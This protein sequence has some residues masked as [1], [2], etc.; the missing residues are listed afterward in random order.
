MA[1]EVL[2]ALETL[3]VEISCSIF[4]LLDP[5]GLISVSQTCSRFRS[6]INPT[7]THLVERLLA[8]ECTEE[9]GGLAPALRS[10]SFDNRPHWDVQE[11]EAMR[12][13]CTSCLRLRPHTSFDNHSLLRLRYRKPI[14]GSPAAAM[15]TSWEPSGDGATRK[16]Q[17]RQRRDTAI[18]CEERKLRRQYGI[19]VTRNWGIDKRSQNAKTRLAAFQDA[20]MDLFSSLTISEFRQLTDSEEVELFDQT[21]LAIE[22]RRCGMKRYRRKCIECRFQ[23]SNLKP[24]GISAV[25]GAGVN[26]GTCNVPIVCSRQL[27]FATAVD[28]YFPD[29]A[30]DL[31]RKE[32][33]LSNPPIPHVYRDDATDEF[34]TMY[35]VRCPAC[36]RWQEL[37]SFRVGGTK[38]TWRPG[39]TNRLRTWDGKVVNADLID[40]FRCYQCYAKEHGKEQ[41]MRE[42]LQRWSLLAE[43]EIKSLKGRLANGWYAITATVG[44]YSSSDQVKIRSEVLN[45]LP[46][47]NHVGRF[48]LDVARLDMDM[49]RERHRRWMVLYTELTRAGKSPDVTNEFSRWMYGYSTMEDMR[50]WLMKCR[51]EIERKPELLLDWALGRDLSAIR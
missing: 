32:R 24:T 7:R 1:Y 27:R 47:A 18:Q 28:R 31:L 13:A 3:P 33:P 14:R 46:F 5:I 29:F 9:H 48:F 12:W 38:P 21:A 23:E 50:T 40:A 2:T 16:A 44:V 8:L 41:L 10:G 42:L 4:R 30:P 45:G 26:S 15:M 20:G 43:H 11:W 25:W 37:R 39:E 49:A 34:W 36:S 35:M 22:S 19:S 17:Q 51:E 6:I